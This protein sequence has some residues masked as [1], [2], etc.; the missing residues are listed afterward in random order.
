M[1]E[2]L[3]T[4]QYLHLFLLG[5]VVMAYVFMGNFGESNSFQLP[6]LDGE[7]LTFF[8]LPIASILI[9]QLVFHN[10]LKR[11]DSRATFEDKFAAYQSASIIRWASVEG[12]AFIIL[13]V[14]PEYAS[15][16]FFVILLL[17]ILR[18]S[19]TRMENDLNVTLRD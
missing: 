12:A 13:F 11:I 17:L 8:A 10:A 9:G 1:K 2:K 4:L 3:K 14:M 6:H 5:G 16:G 15:L 7:S 18:P 19:A